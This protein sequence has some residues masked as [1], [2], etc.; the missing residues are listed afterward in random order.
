[1]QSSRSYVKNPGLGEYT[2][3][4]RRLRYSEDPRQKKR[5]KQQKN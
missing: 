4:A 2:S 1:M 3:D 5:K